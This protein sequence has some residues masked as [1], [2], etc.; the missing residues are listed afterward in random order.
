MWIL[1]KCVQMHDL[2]EP[3]LGIEFIFASGV[4]CLSAFLSLLHHFMRLIKKHASK[5]YLVHVSEIV[6]YLP[7]SFVKSPMLI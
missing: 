7:A 3:R 5:W 1:L 6:A 4:Q 2:I